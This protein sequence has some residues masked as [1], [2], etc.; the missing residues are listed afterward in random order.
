[1]TNL[2]TIVPLRAA[3]ARTLIEQSIG[4]GPAPAL[5]QTHR[6]GGGGSSQHR[7]HDKFQEIID[8][9]NRGDSPIRLKQVILDAPSADDRKVGVQV[10]S[11]AAARLGLADT[12]AVDP[13][14]DA[15]SNGGE[16]V[17]AP[18]PVFTTEAEKQAARMVLDVIGKY[19]V[20]PDRVPTSGALLNP[21]V[22]KEILAELTERLKPLQGNLLA[23][24]DDATLVLDLSFVVAK[25]TEMMVQQTIDIP[26]I[27]VVPKGEVTTGFRPFSLDVSQLRLQPGE[28]EI[29]GQMLRTNEQFTLAAEIGLK[30]QR[31][32]DY[33]VHALVDFDDID[34][35]THA[36]L[37]YDLAG[38]M[39][40]H[41]QSYLSESEAVSVLNRDRRLIALE[42]HA[43]MMAHFFEEAT[44][45][46]VQ[47]SRGFTEL[48]PC[49]Y[50][51]TAGQAPRHFRETVVDVSRIK[52]ILFGGFTKCLYP[53]QKFDSDTE[54][55]FAVILERDAL[56]WF[57]PAKGQFQIYYKLGIEQPEYIPD[58]VVETDAT[59]VMAETKKRDDLK[60]DEVQAKA[61]A[62]LSWCKHATEHAASVGG[63]A[64]KYL[65]VPH[66]E[67][68]ESRRLSDFLR[69]E[70]KA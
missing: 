5:R 56:K 50:T 15:A 21:D 2:Y 12:P 6:R 18:A 30:E 39:A 38:Q 3:N 14:S 40:R 57:K 22:Q 32:E 4:R 20:K 34:Y 29:V 62:A 13:A 54:R 19:E 31:L 65:L 24:A 55:R 35:F 64:W 70:V 47:V 17:L 67:V 66:D 37:L 25:T 53:L 41:L 68:N 23:G 63:K 7:R 44:E 8:E 59:I 33:I 61:A 49:N 58:F 46:E 28:R 45:F 9:A 10:E 27:A 26:R 60:T 1:M 11:C 42:I 69:F 52:Q 48:K 43:Q 16:A 36:D 51:A